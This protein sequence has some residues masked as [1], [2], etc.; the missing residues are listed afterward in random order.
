MPHRHATGI[1]DR[2]HPNLANRLGAAVNLP[3]VGTEL[4]ETHQYGQ[5]L[6]NKG[7]FSGILKSAPAI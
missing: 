5:I 1:G 7:R 6:T 4:S 2:E 3:D